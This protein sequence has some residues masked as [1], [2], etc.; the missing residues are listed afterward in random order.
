[1]ET[2]NRY[3]SFWIDSRHQAVEEYS[4]GYT[5]SAYELSNPHPMFLA[6]SVAWVYHSILLFCLTVFRHE[7]TFPFPVSGSRTRSFS[8][9]ETFSLLQSYPSQTKHHAKRT[10][11]QAQKD[12]NRKW[13]RVPKQ[14]SLKTHIHPSIHPF[15]H[16]HL[17]PHN[18]PKRP[19]SPSRLIPELH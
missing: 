15:M 14:W 1:M 19:T 10:R 13:Y 3:L 6:N 12:K 18:T 17:F 2:S 9:L 5:F 8:S 11:Q 4:I 7:D 16:P